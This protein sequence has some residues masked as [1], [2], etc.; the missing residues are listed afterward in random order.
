M[1]H[2]AALRSAPTWGQDQRGDERMLLAIE[3]G[4][5]W[6]THKTAAAQRLSTMAG[7]LLSERVNL[8]DKQGHVIATV[9]AGRTAMHFTTA[10]WASHH[11]QLNEA[12]D[13]DDKTNWHAKL[14]FQT[15]QCLY[16]GAVSA[17][18]E[19]VEFALSTYPGERE[20]H[21]V[22]LAESYLSTGRHQRIDA[23]I[24]EADVNAPRLEPGRRKRVVQSL[25]GR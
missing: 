2:H 1:C 20:M 19:P 5:L 23:A 10:V 8:L 3:A 17:G 15:Q 6:M 13:P 22:K 21:I 9:A 7:N 25:L 11:R 12:G 4:A 14:V 16:H 18:Q 24:A